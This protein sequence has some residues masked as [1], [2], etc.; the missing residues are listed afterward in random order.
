MV[1]IPAHVW[2]LWRMSGRA[3]GQARPSK[4]TPRHPVTW[5]RPERAERIDGA[6]A[7]TCPLTCQPTQIS[8]PLKYPSTITSTHSQTTVHT[9]CTSPRCSLVLLLIDWQAHR[10]T[11]LHG[12]IATRAYIMK[13]MS[14]CVSQLLN[15]MWRGFKHLEVNEA[16]PN[17]KFFFLILPH[18]MIT[19]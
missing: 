13:E 17:D 7:D 6:K 2:G 16:K 15:N 12:P 9:P 1:C 14:N 8:M 11:S 18:K 4:V 3:P 5:F 19:M 10:L